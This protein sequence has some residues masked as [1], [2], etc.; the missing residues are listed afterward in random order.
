MNGSAMY[1]RPISLL[2]PVGY[3]TMKLLY[4]QRNNL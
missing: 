2:M 1:I 4:L 3:K